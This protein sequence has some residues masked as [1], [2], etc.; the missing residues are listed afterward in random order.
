MLTFLYFVV[1]S[2]IVMATLMFV[3]CYQQDKIIYLDN[4]GT[5]KIFDDSLAL[6]NH[7]Y[8]YYY[9]NASGVY[10][11][12]AKSKKLLETCRKRMAKMLNAQPCEIFFT[13]GATE[14]NNIAIRGVFNKHHN[15]GKHVVTTTIEH[16]SVEET[17][18]SLHGVEYTLLPVDKHGKI[19]LQ[20]LE[21]A[22]R[23]D[24]VLVS[25]I[26]GNN[27]I[28]TIQ[29]MKSIAKLCK[30]KHVHL[31]VDMTQ[32]IGKYFVDM[33]DLGVDS[34]TGSG[35]KFHSPKGSG[36]L[37]LKKGTDIETCCTGGGQESTPYTGNIRS[38]TENIPSIVGM[39]YSLHIC[40]QQL[41]LGKHIEIKQMRDWMRDQI[42]AKVPGS[43]VNGHPMDTMYNTLSMCLPVN[44]RKLIT[45]LDKRKN[46]YINTGSACSK[47]KQSRILKAIG[48]PEELQSGA[49]RVS[50]GFLNTWRETKIATQCIV[51]YCK[52]LTQSS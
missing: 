21:N 5:T 52:E 17:V 46:I 8:M 23:K 47:S 10:S 28:G 30:Q 44:S 3:Y 9:G 51:E 22:I 40:Y 2:V 43:I 7:I 33:K 35:H 25:I 24:T 39:C 16:P 37:F 14:S 48:V 45:M 6:M 38:G 36:F 4:N 12:G 13:S 31:H 11:L 49:V 41:R 32:I 1:A 20:D 29:D 50:F 34:A 27:E 19:D 15:R 18:K 42:L 26:M